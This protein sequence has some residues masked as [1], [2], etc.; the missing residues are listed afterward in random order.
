MRGAV[1]VVTL[2]GVFRADPERPG[3]ADALV[4]SGRRRA[5]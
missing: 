4:E 5:D 3:V 2:A 1:R